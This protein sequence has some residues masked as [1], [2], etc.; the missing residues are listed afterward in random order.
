MKSIDR[1]RVF[2]EN[3]EVRLERKQRREKAR[4]WLGYIAVAGVFYYLG[5][6]NGKP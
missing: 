6:L 4:K 5:Y 2:D 1:T 3:T